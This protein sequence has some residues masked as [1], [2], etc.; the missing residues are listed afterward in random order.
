MM[1]IA[2]PYLVA[3]TLLLHNR[4]LIAGLKHDFELTRRL[5]KEYESEY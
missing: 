2:I 3:Q 4:C 1:E 5:R